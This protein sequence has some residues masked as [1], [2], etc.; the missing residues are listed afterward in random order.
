MNEPT[1]WYELGGKTLEQWDDEHEPWEMPPLTPEAKAYKQWEA[2][3]RKRK[4]DE[5][6]MPA[7]RRESQK[8]AIRRAAQ[9][10]RPAL[11][12]QYGEKCQHC[13]ATERL[14]I[15]HII[16]LSKGGTNDYANLQLLCHSCNSKKGGK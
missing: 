13:G 3:E 12:A 15:D 14:F 10:H 1:Q 11:I 6:R 16:P 5:E 9:E 2:S 8:A 4:Y 7:V